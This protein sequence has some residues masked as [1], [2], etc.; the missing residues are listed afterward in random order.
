MKD[1]GWTVLAV[2]TDQKPE[3][4]QAAL[5]KGQP[6]P[7]NFKLVLDPQSRTAEA[8]GSYMYPESYWVNE[9]GEIE[10]KWVGPQDW[11]QIAES[12]LRESPSKP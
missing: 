11:G 9:K 10:H 7:G 2:S 1:R 4:A 12:L 8:F 3:A 6:L 5:P